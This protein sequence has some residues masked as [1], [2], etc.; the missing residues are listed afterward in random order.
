MKNLFYVIFLCGLACAPGVLFGQGSNVFSDEPFFDVQRETPAKAVTAHESRAALAAPVS[1]RMLP[2]LRNKAM[3]AKTSEEVTLSYYEGE[4]RTVLTDTS[5]KFLGARFQLD[6]PCY[7][8]AFR[9][10]LTGDTGL[11]TLHLHGHEGGTSLPILRNDFIEPVVVEK[12]DTGA[13]TFEV[14]L[15]EP[16]WFFNNQFWIG[17]TD[18]SPGVY[19]LSDNVQ[20]EFGCKSGRQE[21]WWQFF[22]TSDNEVD[23]GEGWGIRPNAF[24]CEA[25]VDFP[26]TETPGYL[27][28]V[29]EQA[30][31]DP[32]L[33]YS[34][35]SAVDFDNDGDIDLMLTDRVYENNGDGAFS[36]VT[37]A[38]G[39]IHEE[40][41]K[42]GHA[43]FD[44]DND[45]DLDL[46]YFGVD[47]TYLFVNDGA[48]NFE[49]QKLDL[50]RLPSML[51]VS[52]TL[53]YRFADVDQDG[54][55]DMFIGQQ[56]E[57]Y[58]LENPE[59]GPVPNYL[60]INNG[61]NTFTDES[62]RLYRLAEPLR[63]SRVRSAMFGDYD[64]DGYPDL[65]VGN[66]LLERDNLFRNNGDGTFVSAT[67]FTNIDRNRTGSN[68]S[69]G[70]DWY[71][72]DNDGT[73]DLMTPQLAHPRYMGPFDHRGTTIYQNGGEPRYRFQDMIGQY[74]NYPG[75]R[76]AIGLEHEEYASNGAWGDLN[77]DGLADLTV[78]SYHNCRYTEIYEQTP[79]HTFDS[80]TFDY[81]LYTHSANG[82]TGGIIYFDYDNDGDLDMLIAENN[83]VRL[84]RNDRPD[85]G[86]HLRVRLDPTSGNSFA[87][88][89]RVEVFAGGNQYTQEVT[90]GKSQMEQKPFRLH[91]GLGA[92]QEVDSV[93][94]WW[95]AFDGDNDRLY[96]VYFPDLNESNEVLLSQG[97]VSVDELTAAPKNSVA[98]YPNPAA[99]YAT[100]SLDR[101][102]EGPGSLSVFDAAGRVVYETTVSAGV[103][104][105]RLDVSGLAAGVYMLRLD[106]QNGAFQEKLVVTA[107]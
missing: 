32:D 13:V 68:H 18:M 54:Y 86:N 106:T 52:I 40:E 71:D 100:L 79:D 59:N 43:F 51:P 12:T 89:A 17:V 30:G 48:G 96:D 101:P 70:I 23:L 31:L 10:T 20:K 7:I 38:K 76:S 104:S 50:P 8:N 94:V 84:F 4:E 39:I 55:L 99:D 3:R 60:F 41:D 33:I 2:G 65:F 46:I 77:N 6:A 35:G 74:N 69:T 15:E 5:I 62:H 26:E 91:F 47:T 85:V 29:T 66:Y 81:G 14:A 75:L 73:L 1:A 63:D 27:A 97:V 64:A 93:R 98:L 82:G 19:W 61:D 92:A 78:I 28:D 34:S 42:F 87:V 58:D 21:F 67:D 36:D 72:Y 53:L 45:R 105:E 56:W 57:A 103:R 24:V 44:S 90:C 22:R 95:N 9:V 83:R 88:G 16:L 107:K 25:D 37:E 102:L 11:A 80:K 49:R